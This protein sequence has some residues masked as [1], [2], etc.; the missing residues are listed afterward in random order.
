MQREQLEH[1]IRAAGVI[2]NQY[3]FIVI[4]S[5]SILGAVRYP[6]AECLMS[7]RLMAL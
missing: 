2:T 7:R 6:P 1:I 3:D 4:G 5:Q